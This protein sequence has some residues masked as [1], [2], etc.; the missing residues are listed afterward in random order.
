[1]QFFNNLFSFTLPHYSGIAGGF[2]DK[3]QLKDDK[4]RSRGKMT[5]KLEKPGRGYVV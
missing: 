2:K 3:M 1:M 5:I 4:M